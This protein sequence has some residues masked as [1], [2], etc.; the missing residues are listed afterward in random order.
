MKGLSFYQERITDE[1]AVYFS[2]EF[3][4]IK[5]DGTVDVSEQLQDAIYSVVK[6]DGYGVLFVPEG[7][8]LL[9]KTIY[10]PKAVRMIGYGKNRPQFVL[11]DNAEGFHVKQQSQK[12]GFKYLFWFTNMMQEDESLIEDANPGT[13][14]SAISNIDVNLG[15]GNPYAVAFRTHY[16]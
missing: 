5:N 2:E 13:F 15:E 10:M 3:F 7:K 16:A 4:D 1:K 9:S 14:Y 12:G 6:Q 8:Y 11:K